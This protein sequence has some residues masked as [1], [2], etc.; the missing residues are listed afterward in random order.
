MSRYIELILIVDGVFA[1]AL[2]ASQALSINTACAAEVGMLL[3]PA[4]KYAYK[5]DSKICIR[6]IMGHEERQPR[7]GEL[8]SKKP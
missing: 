2:Q 8:S 7:E 4:V 3:H 6:Y 5:R 1:K